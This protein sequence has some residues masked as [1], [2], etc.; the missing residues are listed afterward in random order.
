MRPVIMLGA[1]GE[2]LS[3]AVR[4]KLAQGGVAVFVHAVLHCDQVLMDP[5]GGS[6]KSGRERHGAAAQWLRL[7]S[8]P[9]NGVMD[10]NSGLALLQSVAHGEAILKV[11]PHAFSSTQGGASPQPTPL[12]PLQPEDWP[13]LPLLSR[14][15]L[16]VRTDSTLG[17]GADARVLSGWCISDVL[18]SFY[19]YFSEPAMYAFSEPFKF[20]IIVFPVCALIDMC[21]H[22]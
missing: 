14:H 1:G 11:S 12:V 19:V 17:Q 4:A 6:G 9:P 5:Q 15:I 16:Q 8:P 10:A 3:A 21:S 18:L 2:G 22:L 13:P 20:H 7:F